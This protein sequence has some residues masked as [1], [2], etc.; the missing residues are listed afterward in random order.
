MT[1]ILKKLEKSGTDNEIIKVRQ[2]EQKR[3]MFMR[4]NTESLRIR[5]QSIDIL[6]TK[7]YTNSV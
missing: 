1:K 2:S 4:K 7:M 5:T 6:K 3:R